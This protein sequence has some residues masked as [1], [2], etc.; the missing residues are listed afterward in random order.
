MTLT[1]GTKLG[2][3]EV[4]AP[5]GSG[6]MGEVYRA[7][8]ARLNRDVAVKILPAAFARDPERM[9]RFQQEAQAVA[10]L[11][12]PN[13]L[14]IHDFGEHKGSPYLVTEFLE[15]ETLRGRLGSGALP[16]RKAAEFAEQIARGLA[17]AHDKGIVHRDLKPENIFVTRDGRVKI[18]DFGLAK[19]TPVVTP[20]AATL[21]SQTEPGVVMGTVGY[22]SPEQV[23]GLVADHRSDL[24]NLGAILYEMLSGKRAF[25]GQTSV[26]TMSAV[27]KEDPPQ[28]AETNRSVPPAIERIVRHCLEKN[29]EER[30]QS[31]RDVAFALGALSDSGSAATGAVTFGTRSAWRSWV[32]VAA[33]VGLVIAAVALAFLLTRHAEKH[34]DRVQAAILPPPGDGFWSNITQPAAISPDGKFLAIIAMR[35]GHT[36]LWLRRLDQ[37]DAQPIAG[38][39]DASNPFWSPDNRNIAFFVPGKL[40]K[41]NVSGGSVSDI[42]PAGAFGIGGAWSPRGV[43]LFAN[44][45]DALKMVSDGGGTPEPI[46]G[47]ELPSDSLSQMWPAFLLDGKHFLFLQWKYPSFGTPDDNVWIGSIDGEKP[48]RLPLASTNA[49]YSEGYL[50][51]CRDGDLVA[52]KFDLARLEL[53][54]AVLPVVRQIQYHTFLHNGAFTVSSNGILV[55]G[56][57]GTGVNSQ[58]AWLDRTGKTIGTLGEPGLLLRQSISPDGKRVA[59]GIAPSETREKIWIY[60]VE[61]GT[62][63]PLVAEESGPNLYRPIWSPDGKQIAYRDTAGKTSTLIVHNSDGS[64]EERRPGGMHFDLIQPSDWSP[65]GH[66]VSVELTKFQGRGNWQDILRVAEI[67]TGKP[68]FDIGHASGGKFSPDGH[69]LAYEDENSGQVYVTSFPVRGAKIAVESIGGGD[70]RWRGDGQELFYVTDDQ[71]MTAVQVRES[72]QEF[73][74]L[75]SQSLFRLQLPDNVGFYD[76]TRDGKRFLVNVRTWKEQTQP[77]MVITNWTAE[78]QNSRK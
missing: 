2:P 13:I 65:D 7:R 71:M 72:T 32:R 35:N 25:Q 41:V 46:P 11:N 39:E 43:I 61:R 75:G 49:Q 16:V 67:E 38:T 64:G 12:H 37:P 17:A 48:K 68:V 54:G 62:R 1:S 77:L 66:Y 9:R 30:F 8:D 56:T 15:G 19:L 28:F 70:V 10:A 45:G 26:E 53:G 50:L 14:A 23:K 42:C 3:Y 24:F 18:L 63:V 27:L 5:A 69:W 59:V 44:F 33:E 34:D 78:L 4:V 22:M 29:P 58:M 36:Q 55:Y 51:F 57:A 31:A 60:D 21:A 6:G 20:D 76:V 74:V 52:Q 40:K 73:R 47:Y